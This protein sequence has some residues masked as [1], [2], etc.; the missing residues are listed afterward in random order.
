MDTD[1]NDIIRPALEVIITEFDLYAF[2]WLYLFRIQTLELC[3]LKLSKTK[4][5]SFLSNQLFLCLLDKRS[6]SLQT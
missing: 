4:F 3:Y 6:P 2:A 5:T 1:K